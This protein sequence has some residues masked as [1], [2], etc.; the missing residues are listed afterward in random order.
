MYTVQRKGGRRGR[1]RKKRRR[2]KRR[3]AKEGGLPAAPLP[4]EAS[5]TDASFILPAAGEKGA[6]RKGEKELWGEEQWQQGVGNRAG[7]EAYSFEFLISQVV[8]A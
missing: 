2:S 7:G 6:A 8:C 4:R 1:R 3:Q 5:K